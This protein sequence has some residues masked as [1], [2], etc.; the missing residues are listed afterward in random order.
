M[1][2]DL[3]VNA[4]AADFIE[5]QVEGIFD[6]IKAK[7]R[8]LTETFRLSFVA[9]FKSYVEAINERYSKSRSFFHRVDP[10]HLYEFYVPIGIEARNRRLKS[11]SA[12]ILFESTPHV[13]VQGAGGCGKSVLSRHLLLDILRSRSRIPV[14]V[15]L[16][17]L[18]QDNKPLLTLI[19]ETLLQCG[20]KLGP[21]VIEKGLEK[22]LFAILF[23]GFDELSANLR[24]K[25]AREIRALALLSKKSWILTTSR[26]DSTFSNWSEFSAYK[27]LPLSL[28]QA[29]QL[30]ERV[31]IDVALKA[32]FQ[33]DLRERLFEKHKSFLSNPLLLSIMLLTYQDAADIP[34]KLSVFYSQAYEALFQRHD[35]WKG[36]YKR[37]RKCDLDIHDFGKL[38]SAFSIL[39]YDK[40][41]FSFSSTLAIS[42]VRRSCEL[43][44]VKV[45]PEL[46]LDDCVQAVCLLV[47]D[48]LQISYSHRSFQE[49]F[50]AKF[51]SEASSILKSK[52]LSRVGKNHVVDNVL[53]LLHELQP[54]FVQTEFMLPQLREMF[55][56][57]K[58]TSD[59]ISRTAH[60]RFLRNEFDYLNVSISL[61]ISGSTDSTRQSHFLQ[62]LWLTTECCGPMY[63]IDTPQLDEDNSRNFCKTLCK[64]VETIEFETSKLTI[65]DSL[66]SHLYDH[67]CG[68]GAAMLE[69]AWKLFKILEEKT[70]QADQS[71]EDI[72]SLN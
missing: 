8:D 42:L 1:K 5:S 72:L 20:L 9:A 2:T 46:Y 12:N 66:I 7:G 47:E 39:A 37:Q 63:G 54:S 28:E 55:K 58:I 17:S 11:V 50:A 4:I 18:N 32:R 67:G 19:S 43:V 22:G 40:R 34:H 59:K 10:V 68:F 48:G 44:S 71:I 36:G 27:A 23:D 38:F 49:F 53:R 70:K 64:E 60:L 16:R 13:I 30:V 3:D 6:V 14:L 15:E 61:G 65:R 21:D 52:L 41:I 33:N 29:L 26:P 51:I 57:L 56:R 45:D 24:S 62:L 35:A 69:A 25:A 31:P